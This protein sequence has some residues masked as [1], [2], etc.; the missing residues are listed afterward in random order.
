MNKL[1]NELPK[2]EQDQDEAIYTVGDS[3]LHQFY[4][5]NWSASVKEMTNN[6]YSVKDLIE[7]INNQDDCVA[8][9]LEWFDRDFFAELGASTVKL[10]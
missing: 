5:G 1:F 7:Y 2:D 10:N 9:W 8:G 6:F 4:C 3:L